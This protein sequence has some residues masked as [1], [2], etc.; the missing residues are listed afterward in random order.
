MREIKV[1]TNSIDGVEIER[2]TYH[3]VSVYVLFSELPSFIARLY[4]DGCLF[5]FHPFEG[6]CARVYHRYV[7]NIACSGI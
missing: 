2:D 3:V 5:T 6:G 7:I 1:I 4:A